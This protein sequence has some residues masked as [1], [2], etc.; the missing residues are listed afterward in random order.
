MKF[1]KI[2][3]WF[4]A[5][6]LSMGLPA[7][8]MAFD[9]VYTGLLSSHAI[10]GYDTVAYFTQNK[11]VK[12]ETSISAE[13][14]GATWLFVNEEHKALFVANPEAYAPQYG[15]YCAYAMADGKA[16]RVDPKAFSVVDGLLYLNFSTGVRSRWE[17]DIEG[18]VSSA[19]QQWQTLLNR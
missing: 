14:N 16:V 9:P 17:A 4:S 10:Q 6:L 2:V 19:N 18:Y 12:G 8:A 15:G 13:W 7:L 1:S 5:S 11:A 3:R